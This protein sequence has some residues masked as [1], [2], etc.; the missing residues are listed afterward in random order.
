MRSPTETGW[1][2]VALIHWP[3]SLYWA[4]VLSTELFKATSPSTRSIRAAPGNDSADTVC[5]CFI[6]IAT[7]TPASTAQTTAMMVK[8]GHSFRLFMSPPFPLE[9]RS[10][11]SGL[12]QYHKVGKFYARLVF[13]ASY[14]GS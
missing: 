9:R 14:L 2:C 10:K 8:C 6:H 7:P 12:S 11:H 1:F 4:V 13:V 3:S 5:S